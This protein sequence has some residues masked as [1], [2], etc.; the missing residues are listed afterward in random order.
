MAAANTATCDP[1]ALWTLL[2]N[3]LGY[4]TPSLA[5]QSLGHLQTL[6]ADP[7]T[8]Q[9]LA[10]LNAGGGTESGRQSLIVLVHVIEPSILAAKN[11]DDVTAALKPLLDQV[12]NSS[13]FP[14]AFKNEVKAV[15]ADTS[16]MLAPGTGILPPLQKT[17]A[18]AASAQV[19]CIDPGSCTNKDDELLGA[20]YDL[21]SLPQ[22]SGGVDLST[23]VGA[24]KSLVTLD[25]T[26]Q[27]ARTLRLIVE[28][29]KG[30]D[31]PTEPHDARDAVS[32][33]AKQAL[34][35]DEGRKLVPAIEVLV[36]RQVLTELFSFLQDLLYKCTPPHQ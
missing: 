31:D 17:L 24:L 4:L 26:G 2:D 25:A 22:S 29:V 19:R 34:T 3:G 36:Q 9:L 35:A 23:L 14:D 13:S 27:T 1:A 32:A 11:G 5:T 6:L 15:V 8:K 12:Y 7:Y 10:Q 30:S 18:C 21:L 28:S 20:L 16:A 33:L